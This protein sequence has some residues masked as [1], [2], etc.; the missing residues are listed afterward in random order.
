MDRVRWKAVLDDWEDIF[1]IHARTT[2]KLQQSK[3]KLDHTKW[4]AWTKKSQGIDGVSDS[5]VRKQDEDI[6]GQKHIPKRTK[7]RVRACMRDSQR[8]KKAKERQ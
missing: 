7:K 3:K 2:H 6:Q 4:E 8:S 5:V 1:Q